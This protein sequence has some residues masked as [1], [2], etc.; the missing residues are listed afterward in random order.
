MMKIAGCL[1]IFEA[2]RAEEKAAAEQILKPQRSM[3]FPA[4]RKLVEI[5]EDARLRCIQARAEFRIHCKG[6]G[7]IESCGVCR[8]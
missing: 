4:Y 7:T 1:A 2:L 3:L 8:R 6:N 5:T